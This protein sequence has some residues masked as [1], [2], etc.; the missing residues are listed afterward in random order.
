MVMFTVVAPPV[1]KKF[2]NSLSLSLSPPP[3]LPPPR[4]RDD[5]TGPVDYLG[6]KAFCPSHTT[7]KSSWQ[8]HP[9]FNFHTAFLPSAN[10]PRESVYGA[11]KYTQ[12]FSGEMEYMCDERNL[13]V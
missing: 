7:G 5:A 11:H 4:C 8:T 3:P 10:P 2:P 6:R 12:N 9:T 13:K 1:W